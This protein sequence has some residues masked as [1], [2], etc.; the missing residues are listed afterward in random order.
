MIQK[1]ARKAIEAGSVSFVALLYPLFCGAS[2]LDSEFWV[3][4]VL[5]AAMSVSIFM[6]FRKTWSVRPDRTTGWVL[7]IASALLLWTGILSGNKTN[8]FLS[9]SLLALLLSLTSWTG[10]SELMRKLLLP[11]TVFVIILPL[12]NYLHYLLSYPMA[13][14]SATFTASFLK[15]LGFQVGSEATVI[16]L[17]GEKISITTAC[18]GIFQLEAML[19]IGWLIVISVHRKPTLRAAHFIML[20]PI[21]IFTNTLRLSAVILLYM[22][23]GDAAFSNALHTVM[24]LSMVIIAAWL[25]WY[26]RLLFKED[27]V[28]K[29]V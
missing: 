26:C 16:V 18:S 8:V 10:G 20:F 27:A 3:L 23:F 29:N 4:W 5:A 12:L 9:L 11:L 1:D 21:V 2:L 7:L 19:L 14:I 15:I 17:S 22:K 24:G 13:V 28:K 6:G 25:M